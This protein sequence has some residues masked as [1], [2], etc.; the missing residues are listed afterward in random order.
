MLP[1]RICLPFSRALIFACIVLP[2]PDLRLALDV[3]EDRLARHERF[4]AVRRRHGDD[5]RR[6]ADG[7]RPQAVM[8]RALDDRLY[9]VLRVVLGTRS[10]GYRMLRDG[11]HSLDRKRGVGLVLK[12]RH[13]FTYNEAS[14]H[15]ACEKSSI[16]HGYL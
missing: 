5:D 15:C 14:T 3:L 6:L 11:G 7:D 16:A 9:A 1:S 13:C 10:G 2:L 8:H 12:A 4:L